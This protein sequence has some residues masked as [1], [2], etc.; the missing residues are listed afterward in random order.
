[1]NIEEF[2]NRQESVITKR[3]VLKWLEKGYIPGAKKDLKTQ[4][5]ILPNSARIPYTRARAKNT[6]ALRKSILKACMERKHVFYK[7][8][9]NV[10]EE[11]FKY[12]IQELKDEGLIVVRIEDGIEYYDSTNKLDKE[13]KISISNNIEN[14][15]LGFNVLI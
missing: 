14:F 10:T 8:Y 2:I 3:T 15:N 6:K 7:L 5:W 12:K 9:K 4:E 11:E 13:S 1:M